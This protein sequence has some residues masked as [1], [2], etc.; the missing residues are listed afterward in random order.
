MKP[1]E[2]LMATSWKRAMCLE[3]GSRRRLTI[4]KAQR[5]RFY[6]GARQTREQRPAVSGA[7]LIDCA[8]I[9]LLSSAHHL[10]AALRDQPRGALVARVDPEPAQRDAEPV[11]QADQEVDVR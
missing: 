6:S 1:D 5:L 7:A 8:P 3:G 2:V 9:A 4:F 11:A 10:A